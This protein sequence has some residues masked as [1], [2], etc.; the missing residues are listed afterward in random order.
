MSESSP[1][2]LRLPDPGKL[3][4]SIC[5]QFLFMHLACLLVI[6]TGISPVAVAVCLALYV[7]RMFA[8]T[9]GFHRLFAHRTYGTGRVFRFLM[10][11]TGTAA[12]QKGP[13][14]W[15]AHHR[16]HHLLADTEEDLHSPLTRTLWRSHVGWFLSRDS[17]VTEWKLITN[18]SKYPDLRFLDR[19][20][21]LPPAILA[22][23]AFLLGAI[24]QRY[25]PG[26][27]TS[28]WQMLIC[29]FFISTVVLYHGTFTVN[30]LAHIFGKRRFATEDN[31]RNN[32]FV[33]L[34]T[35]GEGWH[36]NHHFY[37]SSERQGFYW[38]EIDVSHYTLRALSWLGIVWDLR[39]PPPNLRSSH[40]SNSRGPLAVFG[41][42][43]SPPAKSLDPTGDIPVFIRD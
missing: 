6:W 5:I 25:A 24:L 3:D 38:W 21:S 36:N 31:S 37:P 43:G 9:A 7:V 8:I 28:G 10:A 22:G 14:W 41:Q 40:A 18:L 4:Y 17:Q 39:T 32:L 33:A 2:N 1:K 13:L 27:G 16:R 15:S 42:K 20:Y 12:Y 35:L 19:Y 29:G 34:I 26:L 11:F 30:S 23:A